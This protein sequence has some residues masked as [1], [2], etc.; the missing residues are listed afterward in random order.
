METRTPSPKSTSLTA[1]SERIYIHLLILYPPRF[2]QA[3][4]REMGLV[5]RSQCRRLVQQEG[6]GAL[7]QLWFSTLSDLVVS[8]LAERAKEGISMSRLMWVQLC[9]IIAFVGGLFGIYLALQAPNEYGNYG[10]HG[11]LAPVAGTLLT[12]GFV[13]WFIAFQAHLHSRATVGFWIILLGLVSMTLG[14][15]VGALWPLIFIGPAL[16]MPIGGIILGRHIYRNEQLPLW[17]RYL[18]L[19]LPAIG[20]LAFFIELWETIV[21]NSAPDRG[22]MMAELLLSACWLVLGVGLWLLARR[23]SSQADLM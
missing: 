22:V 17:S 6:E 21:Q 16:I 7:A 15:L 3:Y 5:F 1:L 19:I 23:P 4:G 10:W 18:P 13:G 12:I 9:G 2:R 14:F 20:V 8:A 11:E